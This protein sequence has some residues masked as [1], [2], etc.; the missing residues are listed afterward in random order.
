MGD[1]D[2]D[3][4]NL[5]ALF[6]FLESGDYAAVERYQEPQDKLKEWI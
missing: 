2:W 5:S 6:I 1:L 3:V 4:I